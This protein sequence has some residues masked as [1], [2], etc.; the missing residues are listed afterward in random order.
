VGNDHPISSQVKYSAT[1]LPQR[2]FDPDKARYHWKK[3]GMGNE[4]IKLHAAPQAFPGAMDAVA[5]YMES[6]AKAG[7]NLEVVREANDGYW[8]HV[9]LKKPF[10]ACAWSGRVTADLMLT[11]AFLSTAPWNHTHWYRKDFDEL[12]IKAR[13]ELDETKRAQ[14]YFELQKMIHE[15]GG[16]VIFMFLDHVEGASKKVGFAKLSGRYEGDG[17]RAAERWW[18]KG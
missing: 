4:A 15:E 1:D 14:M 11:V 16:T 5:L 9:W 18:F 2:T 3:A 10:C 7:I 8:S 13:V 6:L 17:A 12:L